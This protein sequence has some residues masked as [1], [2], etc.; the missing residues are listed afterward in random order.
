MSAFEA[1]RVVLRIEAPGAADADGRPRGIAAPG[2]HRR[3]TRKTSSDASG[4][5]GNGR[6]NGPGGP[7]THGTAK[8]PRNSGSHAGGQRLRQ[9]P[10]PQPKPAQA[11][12]RCSAPSRP[13]D[14]RARRDRHPG[15]SDHHGVHR[16][17]HFETAAVSSCPARHPGAELVRARRRRNAARGHSRRAESTARR[18]RAMWPWI[19]EATVAMRT[20]AS[21]STAD[22]T[23]TAIFPRRLQEPGERPYVEG[24]RPSP[25][26]SSGISTSATSAR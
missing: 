13:P 23:S 4:A 3:L 14:D 24:A 21:T 17:S 12:P 20:G 5:G 6:G 15:G 1:D 22:S 9:P 25:S 8:Q 19:R 26:S 16:G 11:P 7:A 10:A 18:A 2:R